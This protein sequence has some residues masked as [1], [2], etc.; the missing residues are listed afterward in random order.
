MIKK[1]KNWLGIE[2]VKV[3]MELPDEVDKKQGLLE[4]KV[5]F[6]SKTSQEVT[7]LRIKLVER[8]ARGRGEDK[9]IDEYALGQ[10]ELNDALQI[11]ADKPISLNFSL[12]FEALTSE[13]DNYANRNFIFRGLV[14]TAKWASAVKSNYYVIAEATVKGVAL[15]PFVKLPIQLK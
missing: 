6:Y 8:Y 14:K 3:E 12:N 13:M 10:I 9:K 11:P 15:D 1:V 7:G 4:G 5:I 2:G